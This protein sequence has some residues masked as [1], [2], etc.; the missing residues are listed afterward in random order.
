[1][2]F[3]D[4][5]KH[6]EHTNHYSDLYV[7]DTEETRRIMAAYQQHGKAFLNQV[8]KTAYIDIPFAYQPFW[9]A[10]SRKAQP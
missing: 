2:T 4:A 10:V 7:V 9:D 3:Y 6:L 1:M 8:T 5:I